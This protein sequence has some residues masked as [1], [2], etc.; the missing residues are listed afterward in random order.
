MEKEGN[1]SGVFL[2]AEQGDWPG[3][4]SPSTWG[5][6]TPD[7]FPRPRSDFRARSDLGA[8]WAKPGARNANP[9]LPTAW[10]IVHCFHRGFLAPGFSQ[11]PSLAG[12]GQNPL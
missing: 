6:T 12:L 1:L 5:V 7:D 11:F 2:G 10:G 9:K 4:N 8:A 3:R